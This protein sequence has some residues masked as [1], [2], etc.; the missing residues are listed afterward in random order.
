[1]RRRKSLLRWVSV[2]LL[3]SIL[4]V[5]FL[6]GVGLAVRAAPKQQIAT[7]I[8]I[9]EFR[10]RGP[11]GG[12]DEFIELYN[13]T[14]AQADMSDWRI[15]GSNNSGGTGS[16][17][18][19]I[20]PANTILQSGQYYLVTNNSTSGYSGSVA[21]D[22]TY[23]TGITDDGGIALTLPDN[24]TIVDAVGLSSGSAFIEG[25]PL[26]SL[27]SSNQDRSYERKVGGTSGS[28]VDTNDNSSDFQMR[29]P[30]NPQNLSSPTTTCGY[31]PGSIIINE[32][33][34]MGTLASSDD[35]WMELYNPGSSSVDLRNWRLVA[36]D[37]SPDIVISNI[38]PNR[39]TVI[40]A[41]G[42]LLLERG[43]DNVVKDVDAD[44]I[45]FGELDDSNE[46]LRL[47]APDGTIVDTA[48][49]DGGAWPAGT[50]SP[51]GSMERMGVITDAPLAWVTNVNAASWTHTDASGQLIHG[52]PGGAN[53]GYTVTHTPI[54]TSTFTP[55][56][57]VTPAPT[58]PLT[59]VISEVAWAGTK[60]SSD[61][62][63]IE[64]YNPTT[65]D[66]NLT[67][68]NLR[69][70]D[71]S[72]NIK[73]EFKDIVIGAGDY[74]LLERTD[75]DVTDVPADVIYTGSLSNSGEILRLY[76]PNGYLVDTANSNGG[77]WPA[78]ISSTFSSMQRSVIATDSDYTWVTYDA[79]KDTAATKDKD[80]SGNNING[81]PRRANTP[82]NV[83]PT[84]TPRSSSSSSGGSS[85]SSGEVVLTPVLGISEFLPRPGHDWNNDGVVNVSDEFIEIINAGRIDVNLRSYR[86]DDEANLGSPPYTLP[87]LTLKPDERAVFYGSETGILLNDSG[88]TVRLLQGSTVIDAYTYG[89]VAYPDQSWCRLPDRMGY[90]NHPCFPTPNNPNALTGTVPLPPGGSTSYQPPVCLLPDNT[91]EEFVYAECEAGGNGIWNRQY[92]D[93]ADASKQLMLNEPP[94]WETIFK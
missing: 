67:N 85:G 46:I 1:M 11:N 88:D 17:P 53:W 55:S 58:A 52:T 32:V 72:P 4:G 61:D 29:A 75:D 35:E 81:T 56:P 9:S 74:L 22:G 78:G 20:F 51:N 70:S 83:T 79:T 44:Q 15:W 50:V 64:L 16:S 12:N 39:N 47:R 13:P 21:G 24:T 34:W 3:F 59:V 60:A 33:A 31:L 2:W 27:G 45:Y 71:G 42:Y 93:E 38:P 82:F 14:N 69:S 5:G 49:S 10:F 6:G 89:V 8:V 86:L 57:T 30:S 77:A 76:D 23:G 94:K 25:T 68:W 54:P 37:G 19:Y 62:E 36:D 40:P 41:R 63:W 91:P 92:W 48:N 73:A 43:Y 87:D 65:K 80:A 84:P 7:S 26:A 18:R 66:V 90:W 28:C